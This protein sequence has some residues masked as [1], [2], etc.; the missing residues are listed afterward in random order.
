MSPRREIRS[1]TKTSFD[2]NP[3][4]FALTCEARKTWK[5][6]LL[7]TEVSKLCG[8]EAFQ[9]ASESSPSSFYFKYS[10]NGFCE[11]C[12]MSKSNA[13]SGEPE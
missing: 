4:S 1:P 6:G 3:L 7:A 5:Y 8:N 11:I 9:N 12:L 13:L 2:K 10:S